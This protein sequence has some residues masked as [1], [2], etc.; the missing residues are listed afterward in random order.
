MI[1][2]FLYIVIISFPINNLYFTFKFYVFF[3]FFFSIET[4]KIA[5]TFD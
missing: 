4:R 3:S 5:G 1:R 2:I